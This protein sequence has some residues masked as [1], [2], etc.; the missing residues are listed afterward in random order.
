V[1]LGQDSDFT[2]LLDASL[3]KR[4]GFRANNLVQA[5][6]EIGFGQADILRAALVKLK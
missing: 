6:L 1:K 5:R 4:L 2:V 3:R